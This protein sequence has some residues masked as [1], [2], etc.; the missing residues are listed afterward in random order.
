M[1]EGTSAGFAAPKPGPWPDEEWQ[2]WWGDTPPFHTPVVV[3]THHPRPPLELEGGNTFHFVDAEPAEALA[4]AR[5]LAG[6]LDVRIGGGTTTIREFLRAD[7]IDEMHIAVVPILLGRG[8][9][10]WDGLEGLEQR[11]RIETVASPSGVI[12]LTFSRPRK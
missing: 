3:L 10:L 4:R 6:G 1:S 8:E 2:G 12:H 7:L 9:R 11:F 5:D